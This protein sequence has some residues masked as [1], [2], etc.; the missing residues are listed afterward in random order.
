MSEVLG[1]TCCSTR[2]VQ[3]ITDGVEMSGWTV[4][5]ETDAAPEVG[6]ATVPEVE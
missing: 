1:A 3:E 4:E 2:R 6:L 5:G